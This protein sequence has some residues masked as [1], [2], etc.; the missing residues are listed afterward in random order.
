MNRTLQ[1]DAINRGQIEGR[2]KAHP[3]CGVLSMDLELLRVRWHSRA[4]RDTLLRPAPDVGPIATM[5]DH[6]AHRN[7]VP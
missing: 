1:L 5:N 3:C 6:L 2:T 7:L 4:G